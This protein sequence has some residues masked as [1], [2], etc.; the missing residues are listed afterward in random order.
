MT[1]NSEVC[2]RKFVSRYS[3]RTYIQSPAAQ[4]TDSRPD[5]AASPQPARI[6][7]PSPRHCSPPSPRFTLSHPRDSR[8]MPA[9]SGDPRRPSFVT[10]FVFQRAD[11]DDLPFDAYAFACLWFS[12][13]AV[14]LN[15]RIY[16]WLNAL[17]AAASFANMRMSAFDFKTLFSQ[18]VMVVLTFLA[19]HGGVR[20]AAPAMMQAAMK[21]V[22]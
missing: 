7:T 6:S 4:P 12:L 13:G 3:E 16:T 21:K 11:S 14:L 9:S 22:A 8:K 2:H 19:T 10:P 1:Q 5:K 15:A 18:I 20:P 17:C